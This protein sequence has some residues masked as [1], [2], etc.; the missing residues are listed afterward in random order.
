MN[1]KKGYIII[2]MIIICIKNK[3]QLIHSKHSFSM[4]MNG[5]GDK[6]YEEEVEE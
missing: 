1:N 3:Q 4:L 5:N 2:K 6:P